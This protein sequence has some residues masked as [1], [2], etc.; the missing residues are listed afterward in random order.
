MTLDLVPQTESAT[1]QPRRR[2]LWVRAVASWHFATGSLAARRLLV[3]TLRPY[4]TRGSPPLPAH[5]LRD[6]GLPEDFQQSS[7]KYWDHQ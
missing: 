1:R 2:S 4:R 5:L 6:I 3:K 7:P